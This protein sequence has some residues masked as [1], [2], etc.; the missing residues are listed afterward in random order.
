MRNERPLLAKYPIKTEQN[1]YLSKLYSDI[2][3]NHSHSDENGGLFDGI[4]YPSVKNAYQEYNIVLHPRSMHK[5]KFTGA[6][7]VWMTSSGNQ[8][9]PTV[10][11][12]PWETASADQHGTIHW[13]QFRLPKDDVSG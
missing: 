7:Y 1:Y 8:N 6:T 11:Y 10:E 4:I 2:I 12:T 9:P 3:F 5:L 13:N